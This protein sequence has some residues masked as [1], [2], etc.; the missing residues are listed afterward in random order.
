MARKDLKTMREGPDGVVRFARERLRELEGEDIR[1]I[2]SS[3][4]QKS[5]QLIHVGP[6]EILPPAQ[7][8]H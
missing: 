8:I 3:V 6:H 2:S 5:A 7:K 1:S 4:T